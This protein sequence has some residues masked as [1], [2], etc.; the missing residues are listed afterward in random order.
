MGVNEVFGRC[1]RARLSSSES[2][3]SL[4]GGHMM[5]DL[6]SPDAVGFASRDSIVCQDKAFV[7]L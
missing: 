4:L 6:R 1:S 7:R 3:V 2:K 5:V